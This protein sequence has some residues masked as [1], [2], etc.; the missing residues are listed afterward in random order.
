MILKGLRR[1]TKMKAI[2]YADT[3]EIESISDKLLVLANDINLEFN[4]LFERFA[5]V[6]RGTQEWIGGQADIYFRIIAAERPQYDNLTNAIR[7]ISKEL[8]IESIGLDN[9]IDRNNKD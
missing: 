9:A 4:S 5:E 3:T 6:P 1:K 8:K 2:S 7:N